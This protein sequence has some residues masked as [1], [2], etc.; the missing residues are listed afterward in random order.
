MFQFY[1]QLPRVAS[2]HVRN[3]HIHTSRYPPVKFDS[4]ASD[5]KCWAHFEWAGVHVHDAC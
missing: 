1:R 5:E 4:K 3:M 2:A